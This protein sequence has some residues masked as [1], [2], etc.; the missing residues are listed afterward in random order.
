MSSIRNQS[1]QSILCVEVED[2]S[3]CDDDESEE[4]R[5]A[6]EKVE[7]ANLQPILEVMMNLTNITSGVNEDLVSLLKTAAFNGNI[8]G[9]CKYMM[10]NHWTTAKFEL[11]S[12][13]AIRLYQD[14]KV[15][16]PDKIATFGK[17]RI[18]LWL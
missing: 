7:S 13:N 9:I 6:Q 11:A 2:V 5:Y 12:A 4:Y 8:S 17:I 1:I 14:V 18:F 16:F 10:R 15:T 3:Y